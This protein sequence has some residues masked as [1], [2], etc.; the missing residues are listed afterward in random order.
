MIDLFPARAEG[1]IVKG[2][3]RMVGFGI[4][5]EENELCAERY[6]LARD[7]VR[8]LPEELRLGREGGSIDAD[9]PEWE[10]FKTGAEYINSITE[11]LELCRN[12]AYEELS[13]EELKVWNKRL[14]HEWIPENYERSFLN[15]AYAVGK[16]GEQSGQLLTVA[17]RKIYDMTGYVFRGNVYLVTILAELFLEL[18]HLAADEAPFK[19]WKEAW[20]YF[21]HDYLED[22]RRE[23]N[24]SFFCPGYAVERDIIENADLSDLR[25]LYRYGRY[26]SDNEI[27]VAKFLMD[28]TEEELEAMAY[29]CTNGYYKGF[30]AYKIDLSKKSVVEVRYPAGFERMA[31]VILR[32]FREMG[33]EATLLLRSTSPNRQAD[34]DHRFDDAVILDK[35]YAD[36][37]KAAQKKVLSELA[38]AAGQMAGP[39]VVMTF[40]EVPF[41]PVKK[42]EA[43]SYT[44]KQREISVWLDNELGMLEEEYVPGE[45]TSFTIIAYP[46]PEIGENFTEIFAET[47]K[48][49]TLPG[50]QYREIQQRLID[51]LDEGEF[52]HILGA[53]E[54]RTDLKVT[55]HP[56]SDPAHQTNFENC[57]D[58]VNIPL[59]EVF[60]SPL[61]TGTTGTLHVTD[62]YLRELRYQDLELKFVDGKIAEYSCANFESEAEN[63]SY[64][65]ENLLRHHETLPLGE[66]AIGTNTTAYVMGRKYDIQGKLPVLIAE[67]T[68]PHFAVGDTCY[69]R[70]E[71]RAVYNPDGKEIIARDNE[72][73]LLRKT[74]PAKAYF[75][76]HTDITIPYDELKEIA[77]Y[78][79]DGSRVVL[80]TDGR[81]VLPGT[82]ELNRAL[83]TLQG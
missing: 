35:P 45:E 33:L 8:E 9:R 49:N 18:Y 27:G 19:E 29:T 14:F 17:Y 71:D 62:T 30:Q 83:D 6:E 1:S 4:Y 74:D 44:E 13:L 64:I 21:S 37:F 75:N 66:F 57:L 47:V 43:P 54:N 68:G 51:A 25:Y 73:S 39:A 69:M 5:Q 70:S 36:A 16:C 50:D 55:L 72:H 77:V 67:K 28:C 7:R 10:F 11:L 79:A 3:L 23:R 63:K 24:R 42:P 34:F 76:T 82:E 38:E 59:G 65:E 41:A 53:G 46:I 40:G 32:Q 48:V 2:R 81:F 78:R 26:V 31:R 56:L 52:V 12:G 20:Y 15:P 22:F 80:I 61:L 58:D 60:T